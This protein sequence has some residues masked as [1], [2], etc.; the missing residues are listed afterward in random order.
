[1]SNNN[2]SKLTH[3]QLGRYG[4]YFAKMEFTKKGFDVYSAEVDDK[5]ID[6]VVRKDE[7]KYFDIQV[8]SIR[9]NNYIYMRKEV[10]VP[11]KNLL[12]AVMLFVEGETPVLLLIPS[13]DWKNKTR[14]FLVER[15]YKG[16]KSKPEWGLS[17]TKSNLN[18]I[19]LAYIFDNQVSSL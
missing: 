10:F 5:G 15:N 9:N 19:R 16:K 13:L 3:L 4:E 2:W 6:F 17:I 14:A 18:E 12:L 1:M 7:N 11:R 8:K